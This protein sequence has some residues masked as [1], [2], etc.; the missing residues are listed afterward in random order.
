MICAITT[1]V[2]LKKKKYVKD[3][4]EKVQWQFSVSEVYCYYNYCCCYYDDDS[5][6]QTFEDKELK[7][8]LLFSDCGE[9]TN[10][11]KLEQSAICVFAKH[12]FSLQLIFL[13]VFNTLTLK[14]TLCS[15]SL[16]TVIKILF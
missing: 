13:Q 3:V 14:H 16:C 11:I 9:H 15:Y 12:T 1:S 7:Q 4:K 8:I 5:I 10:Q 6:L 2:A